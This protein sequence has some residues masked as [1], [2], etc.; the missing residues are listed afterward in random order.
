MGVIFV[1]GVHGVGKSTHCQ[2]YSERFG[3]RW[4]TASALI[5]A[6]M[7]TAIAKDSKAVVSPNGNQKLLLRSVHALTAANQPMLL[8][9]HF[10]LL[11]SGGNIVPIDVE[12]F[13]QLG[14]KGVVLIQDQP[15]S[16]CDRL[17]ERDGHE[18]SVHKV[19]L[20]QE[21]EI[22]HA[23]VVATMIQVPMLRIEAFDVEC[24]A[25]AI[26]SILR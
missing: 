8:D 11:D 17:R 20:Q 7:Q 12:I 21:A 13:D 22:S 23:Q 10:T 24:F 4:F 5:R 26:G 14:L 2:L 16:I 19:S 1:G 3:M 18:W 9:G 15:E 6:E 25:R